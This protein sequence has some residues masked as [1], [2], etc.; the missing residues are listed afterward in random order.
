MGTRTR[1]AWST[2]RITLAIHPWFGEEVAVRRMHGV[3]AVVIERAGGEQRIV[4]VQWTDLDPREPPVEVEGR[5]VRLPLTGALE[6]GAWIAAR[7]T[8][9][10]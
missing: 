2:A 5:P 10:S 9:N 6:L 4:P 7:K 8:R 3:D 1:K